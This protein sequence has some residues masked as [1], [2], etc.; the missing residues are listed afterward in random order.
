MVQQRSPRS[1][2]WH[3]V[4]EQQDRVAAERREPIVASEQ[5]ALARVDQALLVEGISSS[6]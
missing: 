6:S 1:L 5:S 4:V 2:T 3:M